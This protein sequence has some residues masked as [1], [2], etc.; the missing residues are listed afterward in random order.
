M[1][2]LCNIVHMTGEIP[3]ELPPSRIRTLALLC[4]KYNGPTALKALIHGWI[5]K[6]HAE[7]RPTINAFLL[8]A[9]CCLRFTDLVQ[10][11]MLKLVL[12]DSLRSSA[13]HESSTIPQRLISTA[14][15]STVAYV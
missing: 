6:Y 12:R 13:I 11:T 7:L 9:A 5:Y 3:T 2:L 15:S 14:I 10:Q 8:E 1:A 4:D